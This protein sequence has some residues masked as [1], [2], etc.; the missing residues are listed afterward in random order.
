MRVLGTE[1]HVI[2]EPHPEE[3]LLGARIRHVRE[4]RAREKS[5]VWLNQYSDAANWGTHYRLTG[6]ELLRDFPDLT[7]L[8][9]GVG[10]T[11]TL[12]GCARCLRSPI[13]AHCGGSRCRPLRL[14]CC[15]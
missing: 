3:G 5:T 2:T 11:G 14:T 9:V 13:P 8:F 12:M 15:R 4:M 7:L 10:T 6:P 1:V